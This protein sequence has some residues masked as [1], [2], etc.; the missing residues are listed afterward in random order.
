M[1]DRVSSFVLASWRSARGLAIGFP[2]IDIGECESVEL[3]QFTDQTAQ[4]WST[5]ELKF[6][7]MILGNFIIIFCL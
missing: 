3:S 4:S 2:D 7:P 6:A 5:S 1:A